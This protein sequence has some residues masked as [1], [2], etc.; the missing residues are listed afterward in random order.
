MS[1]HAD[2]PPPLCTCAPQLYV[3]NLVPGAVNDMTLRQLFSSALTSV[4]PQAA[5]P[6]MEPVISVNLHSDGRYAF[7]EFRT[8]E[9]ATAAL[10]LNG[11]VQLLG[12]AISVG[13]PSGFV[14]PTKAT[15]AAAAAAQALAAFQVR[16]P[17]SMLRSH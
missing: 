13:R 10:S 3:G 7:V 15:Q 4:F 12:Q 14:D 9:M 11:V 17:P 16:A 1:H 2:P 5:T 6:G 8:P